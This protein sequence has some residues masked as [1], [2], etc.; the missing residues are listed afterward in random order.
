MPRRRRG[1]PVLL[2]HEQGIGAS[3]RQSLRIPGDDVLDG[4]QTTQGVP[5]LFRQRGVA[6]D[7]VD[8][9]QRYRHD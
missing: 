6:P 3:A 1:P 4:G 9:V 7:E 8:Q 2:V 5:A